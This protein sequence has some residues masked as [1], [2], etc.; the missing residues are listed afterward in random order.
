V[1]DFCE[2]D[3]ADQYLA[4]GRGLALAQR[5]DRPLARIE[6]LLAK[7]ELREF[8]LQRGNLVIELGIG[9]VSAVNGSGRNGGGNS[10]LI[11]A[12]IYA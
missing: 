8:L 3:S 1:L 6:P 7:L 9:I 4:A 11:F 2:D 12:Y 5:V 10:P